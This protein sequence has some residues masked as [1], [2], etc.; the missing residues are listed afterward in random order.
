MARASQAEA[1]ETRRRIVDLSF[2][3]AMNE[4]VE[5]IT[6]TNIANRLKMAR[7]ATNTHFKRKEDLLKELSPMFVKIIRSRLVFSSP[8][9]FFTS[10][11]FAIK[12]DSEFRR[13]IIASGDFIST[14]VGK[15]GLFKLIKGEPKEVEK[16]VYMA[17]GFAVFHIAE[18]EE[19]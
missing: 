14:T 9:D 11:A 6:F 15:K 12:N 1:Q 13:A 8:D 17:I 18:L 4:G 2:D 19:K 10:W 16:A 3:I 7:S 5:H